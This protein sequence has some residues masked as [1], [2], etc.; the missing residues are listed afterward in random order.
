VSL[1]AQAVSAHRLRRGAVRTPALTTHILFSSQHRAVA[2]GVTV[3]AIYR[4]SNATLVPRRLTAP[5]ESA[6]SF[7]G[8]QSVT[9]KA[10]SNAELKRATL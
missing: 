1:R 2:T 5:E 9:G 4:E 7:R 6:R 3:D 10:R 8:H